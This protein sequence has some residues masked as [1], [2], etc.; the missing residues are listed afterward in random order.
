MDAADAGYDSPSSRPDSSTDAPTVVVGACAGLPTSGAW[1][2]TSISPVTFTDTA[3]P[4]DFTGKSMA[5]A[6]DPFDAATV[7]LGTGN[8]GLF[9]SGDCG[10]T[11]THVN[12]GMN[13]AALDQSSIWSMVVDPVHQG[14]IYAAA[15]YGTGYLWKSVNGGV[16]WVDIVASSA[17]YPFLYGS[18]ADHNNSFVNN[19]SMDPADPL[20]LV[21]MSHGNC[22]PTYP[23]GCI[24]ETMDGGLTWPNIV[25]MPQPWSEKGGVQII[26]ATTWIWGGGDQ[27]LGLYVTTDNGKTW[28]QAIP[29]GSGDGMGELTTQPLERAS[30]GAFYIGSIEGV[31]RST[32]GVAWSRAWQPINFG[33]AVVM[34][35]AVTS[36]T[37]YGSDGQF[38][39]APLGDYSSWS[40]MTSPATQAD[41]AEFL[42]LD[43]AHHLLYASCWA[44]GL[45]R[46]GVP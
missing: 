24:A 45:Y 12:S 40:P 44:G 11:W 13:G 39:S 9:R 19:V 34:A 5:V 21:A 37:I 38:Y 2:T 46:F 42:A 36:T 18:D 8:S 31:L 20:H 33:N 27:Q 23:N 22:N 43:T 17:W 14:T 7:W 26:D 30:D 35:V 29:G 4:A 10:A 16:D 41:P 1:D 6:V 3:N 28:T 15:A 32:D 25:S